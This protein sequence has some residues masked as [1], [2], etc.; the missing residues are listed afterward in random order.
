MKRRRG[1][2]ADLSKIFDPAAYC[3][4]LA[5]VLVEQG[6]P[7]AHDFAHTRTLFQHYA[8]DVDVNSYI[9]VLEAAGYHCDCEVGYNLCADLGI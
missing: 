5:R 1:P 6:Q 2:V 7:C 8:P 3:R 4:G 9:Q